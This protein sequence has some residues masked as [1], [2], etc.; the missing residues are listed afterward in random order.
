MAESEKTP[1]SDAKK[2]ANAL[3]VW[4]ALGVGVGLTFGVIFGQIALGIA[5]GRGEPWLHDKLAEGEFTAPVL[6]E[7]AAS[8]NVD[9]PVSNAVAAILRGARASE[10]LEDAATQDPQQLMARLTGNYRRGNERAA[11]Q[12]PRNQASSSSESN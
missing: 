9:M 1:G 2:K 5:L 11:R 4:I 10:F 7:L 8:Q 3:G 6:I 12:H